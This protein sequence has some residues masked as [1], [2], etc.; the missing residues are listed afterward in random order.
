VL[1]QPDFKKG[2]TLKLLDQL[3]VDPCSVVIG[4]TEHQAGNNFPFIFEII[5]K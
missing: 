4:L 2:E 5:E 1:L 3:G